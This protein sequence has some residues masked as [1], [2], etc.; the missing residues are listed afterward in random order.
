MFFPE[1]QVT[2]WLYAQPVNMRCSFDGLAALAK[3]QLGENPIS[4]HL[5]VFINRRQTQTKVL[6]YDRTGFCVW[7]KR[8]ESGRF[9]FNK[10]AGDK[11][12]LNWTQLKLMIEGIDVEN[13]HQR[14]RYHSKNSVRPG[15]IQGHEHT[16][17]QRA[18]S[19]P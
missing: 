11:Q 4:G 12:A 6:Y 9:N 5:F 3:N 8:L 2:I 14:K 18:A 16:P 7:S 17:H 13:T 15:I 1:S 10:N 19:P